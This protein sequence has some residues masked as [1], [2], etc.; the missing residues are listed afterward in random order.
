[1]GARHSSWAESIGSILASW[2][3]SPR[4]AND[5]AQ[6]ARVQVW[7][8]VHDKNEVLIGVLTNETG[9]YVFRYDERY[10]ARADYPALAAFPDKQ[11]EYRSRDLWPFFDVRLPPLKRA[12]VQ[13]VIRDRKIDE[14]DTLRLLA[15]LGRR[16]IATPY[17]LKYGAPSR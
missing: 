3:I 14:G 9:A 6:P 12:D 17:E 4:T 5:R 16:T 8:P 15:E 13:R 11:R 7:G 10:A 2:G 1:M